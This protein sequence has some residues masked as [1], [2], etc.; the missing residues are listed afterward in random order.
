MKFINKIIVICILVI[1]LMLISCATIV[2]GTSHN[3]SIQ[4]N[5]AGASVKINGFNMGTTPT[6]LKLSSSKEHPISIELDG[7]E[8]Y[9]TVITK[10]VSGWLIGN[11]LIGGIPGLIIDVITGGMYVLNTEQ[12]NAE[13]Q[14]SKHGSIDIENGQTCLLVTL[15]SDPSWKKIGQL[16][17]KK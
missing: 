5:P 16:V 12:L 9:N 2:T 4:S 15:H 8:T 11:I 14:K 3:V 1:G 6:V 7:Y 17:E 13:L 10:S